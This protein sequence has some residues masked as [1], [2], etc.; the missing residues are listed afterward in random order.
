MRIGVK[1]I[2]YNASLRSIRKKMGISQK[3]LSKMSGINLA[4]IMDFERLRRIPTADEAGQ[5]AEVLDVSP[6]EIFPEELYRQIVDRVKDLGYDFYF[7]VSP[8]SLYRKEVFELEAETNRV[9]D[10]DSEIDRNIIVNRYLSRL[11]EREREIL[12][13]RFGLDGEGSK[14]LEEVGRVYGVTRERVR[15]IE[16]K[17]IKKLKKMFKEEGMDFNNLF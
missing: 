4:K 9:E 7:D 11:Q 1:R 13:L 16:A 12:S 3:R 8:M 5:V 2:I 10:I 6:T 17:A 14:T 15:G